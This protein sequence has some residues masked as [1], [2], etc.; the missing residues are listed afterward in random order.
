MLSKLTKNQTFRRPDQSFGCCVSQ[1]RLS[2]HEFCEFSYKVSTSKLARIKKIAL[3]ESI[4]SGTI[5]TVGTYHESYHIPTAYKSRRKYAIVLGHHARSSPPTLKSNQS[6]DTNDPN[7]HN[8][9]T[10]PSKDSSKK[11]LSLPAAAAASVEPSQKPSC[12][13]EQMSWY[14]TSTKS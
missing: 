9:Q 5:H 11:R 8:R 4:R 2:K 6:T 7:R 10:C 13:S 12:E 14:A 1:R 3:Y